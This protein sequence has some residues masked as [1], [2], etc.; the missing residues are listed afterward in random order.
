M[1]NIKTNSTTT[2]SGDFDEASILYRVEG[3]DY[4]NGLNLDPRMA[5]T[6]LKEGKLEISADL[7]WIKKT[8]KKVSIV[9]MPNRALAPKSANMANAKFLAN[10]LVDSRVTVTLEE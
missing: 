3:V 1:L 4:L 9:F 6:V 7:T 2:L 10:R 5:K 8:T